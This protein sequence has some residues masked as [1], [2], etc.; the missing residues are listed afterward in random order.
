MEPEVPRRRRQR[1]SPG[2]GELGAAV[3]GAVHPQEVQCLAERIRRREG[4]RCL[5]EAEVCLPGRSSMN[6]RSAVIDSPS[7]SGQRL[8]TH[9]RRHET[10]THPGTRW[11]RQD[12]PP[13]GGA[14]H[15]TRPAGSH[16]LALG[17]AAVRLGGPHDLGPRSGRGRIG[18]RLPLL[19]RESGRRG[20]AG[21]VRRA[22]RGARRSAPR[23]VVRA[24]REGGRAW[25]AGRARLRRRADGPALDLVRPE[26]Q[27]GLLAGA[28]LR[29]TRSRSR[30]E[31]RP[32]RSST[33]TTSPT[34]RSR[35]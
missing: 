35:R 28:G 25:G 22:G 10:H 27:R 15:C 23:P 6:R 18:L 9:E 33:P 31:T 24:R 19:G 13:R 34:S 21:R 30:P 11:H 8:S 17:R 2:C 16:R 14:P 5:H 3:V 29:A 32:S 26:L 12:R 20:D 4:I 1:Q 7:R